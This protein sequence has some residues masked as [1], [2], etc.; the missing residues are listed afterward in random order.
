MSKVTY[1]VDMKTGRGW[2]PSKTV[3]DQKSI[4]KLKIFAGFLNPHFS[5]GWLSSSWSRPCWFW[6]AFSLKIRSPTK[7]GNR[8]VKLDSTSKIRWKQE[9]SQQTWT[10]TRF[11]VMPRIAMTD[12]GSLRPQGPDMYSW[13]LVTIWMLV[14]STRNTTCE[15]GLVLNPIWFYDVLLA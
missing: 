8:L 14:P 5:N 12:L 1:R 15:Q 7:N 6:V 10:S 3:D 2:S 13:W 4:E 9:G 11:N